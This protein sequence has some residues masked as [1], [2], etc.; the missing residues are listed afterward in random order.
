MF[1]AAP[2]RLSLLHQKVVATGLDALDGRPS[3]ELSRCSLAWWPVSLRQPPKKTTE[4][5]EIIL[6]LAVSVAPSTPGGAFLPY[7]EPAPP[8]GVSTCAEP[9]RLGPATASC[10]GKP[11]KAP[12]K[13]LCVSGMACPSGD[14]NK[15]K[16][17]GRAATPLLPFHSSSFNLNPPRPI[18][19]PHRRYQTSSPLSLVLRG[20]ADNSSLSSVH[21]RCSW[22]N[23]QRSL[24]P[25]RTYYRLTQR[26]HHLRVV[27]I[28]IRF[29]P[30]LSIIPAP[31]GE[32]RYQKSCGEGSTQCVSPAMAGSLIHSAPPP[33]PFWRHLANSS[34]QWHFRIHQL[35][36][37]EGPQVH[38]RHPSQW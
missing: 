2:S 19:P 12:A 14:V 31:C 33:P 18:I 28:S 27:T 17:I 35:P 1:E 22:F 25:P 23:C 29:S 10:P 34:S 16:Y 4:L 20:K 15:T 38:P 8:Q 32:Y 37:R 13:Q 11:K 36:C 24:P 6:P 7:L 5:E 26:Q 30:F 3:H 9:Q 21:R